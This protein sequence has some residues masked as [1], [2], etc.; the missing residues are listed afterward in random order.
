MA[1]KLSV[2]LNG[3]DAA[4]QHSCCKKFDIHRFTPY[5]NGSVLV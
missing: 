1:V 5:I 3:M 4:E 2:G